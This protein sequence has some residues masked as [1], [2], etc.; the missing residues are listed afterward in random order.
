MMHH[1]I[2]TLVIG[3]GFA[4]MTLLPWGASV[5]AAPTVP[6]TGAATTANPPVVVP[7]VHGTDA[8]FQAHLGGGAQIAPIDPGFKPATTWPGVD[9]KFKVSLP[10]CAQ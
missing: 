2:R 4:A 1:S 3:I 5:T 10:R 7:C 6:P 9:P 8:G